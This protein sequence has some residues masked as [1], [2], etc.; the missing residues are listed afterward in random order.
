MLQNI[1]Y[2]VKDIRSQGG[3]PGHVGPPPPAYGPVMREVDGV[4][5]EMMNR[6]F[7]PRQSKQIWMEL[8]KV[9]IDIALHGSSL[10]LLFFSL[11]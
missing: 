8:Y 7:K 3:G 6:L 2:D 9:M 11:T 1:Q 4:K 10:I 5:Q